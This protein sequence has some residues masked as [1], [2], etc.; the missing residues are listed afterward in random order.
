[1]SQVTKTARFLVIAFLICAGVWY[2]LT[3]LGPAGASAASRIGYA[4]GSNVVSAAFFIA[5]YG[6]FK[7]RR[8]GQVL[9]ILLSGVYLLGILENLATQG[10]R[11]GLLVAAL[12]F[13]SVVVWLLHPRVRDRF[14][15]R[16]VRV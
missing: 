11:V 4:I 15:D 1:M 9:A 12:L 5:A 6:I 8:W 2:L 13:A 14:E 3:H 16:G 7:W 10:P